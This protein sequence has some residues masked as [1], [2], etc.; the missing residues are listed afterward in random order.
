M[1]YFTGMLYG[2]PV[3]NPLSGD[4]LRD[5]AEWLFFGY[6]VLLQRAA[7]GLAVAVVLRSQ[8]AGAVVGIILFVGEAIVTTT[9]TFAALASRFG[10]DFDPAPGLGF[11]PIGPE[12]F[13]YLPISVGGNVLSALPGGSSAGASGGLAEL[14][15][16]PVPFE[17]ALPTVL[18]YLVVSVGIAVFALRRQEII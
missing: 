15:L 7:L 2:I 10:G 6:P 8:L 17:L 11:E 12:W 4:G 14:F 16:N 3:S 9:L 13:Q 5:L 1:T 18:I